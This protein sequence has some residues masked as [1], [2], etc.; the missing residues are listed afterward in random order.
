MSGHSSVIISIIKFL[1]LPNT[2]VGGSSK[3]GIFLIHCNCKKILMKCVFKFHALIH[4]MP[5]KPH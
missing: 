1:P 3:I 4:S 2:G 5:L